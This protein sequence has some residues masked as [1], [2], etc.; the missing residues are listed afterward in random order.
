MDYALGM[1][2]FDELT[3]TE[4]QRNT[5]STAFEDTPKDSHSQEC[6]RVKA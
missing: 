3:T 4:A 1:A 6:V 5:A 2:V